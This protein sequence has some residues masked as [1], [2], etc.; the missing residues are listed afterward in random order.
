M[1]ELHPRVLELIVSRVC[2]DLVSPVGAVSNGVELMEELGA[3]A[4][5]DAMGLI[6]SSAVQAARRLKCF[7]LAY[8]AAGTD[9]NMGFK[10]I[11]EA[12]E[13]WLLASAGENIKVEFA[14]DL[15]LKFSMPP[16]GFI[17]T[18]LNL[19]MLAAECTHGN[20]NIK[21]SALDG[22]KGIEIRIEGQKVK[23]RD[24]AES[25]IRGEIPV[26]DLDART[27]HPYLSGKF[28]SY[29]GLKF[30]SKIDEK[31][32]FICMNLEF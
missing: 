7:R 10:E 21:V 18:V 15:T 13:G 3:D 9:G 32:P 27:C 29:F 4:A 30:S 20:G 1:I 31:A 14:D 23:F 8:G 24:N 5:D 6:S 22:T 17:K 26:E 2:H 16:K 12:F 11:K 25:A 19:L 28:I